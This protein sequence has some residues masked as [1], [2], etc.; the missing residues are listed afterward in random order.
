L[1]VRKKDGLGANG[2]ALLSAS[3]NFLFGKSW[4]FFALAVLLLS[5]CYVSGATGSRALPRLAGE[6]PTMPVNSRPHFDLTSELL[7]HNVLD[8]RILRVPRN[9]GGFMFQFDH[10]PRFLDV[11]APQ[12]FRPDWKPSAEMFIGEQKPYLSQYGLQARTFARLAQTVSLSR[13]GAREFLPALTAFLLAVALAVVLTL[14]ARLWGFASAAA[15]LAFCIFSTGLNLFSTSLYWVSFLLAAPMSLMALALLSEVQSFRGWSLIYLAL[16]ALFIAK[17]LAGYE[18]LTLVASAAAIPFFLA[19][20]AGRLDGSSAARHVATVALVSLVSFVGAAALHIQMASAT[21]GSDALTHLLSRGGQWALVQES[22][23]AVQLLQFG[24]VGL[25]NLVDL[26][27]YGVPTLLAFAA[28]G[29]SLVLASRSLLRRE[30]DGEAARIVLTLAAAF[31]VSVSWLIFQPQHVA[32]HPRYVAL[33]LAFPFGIVASAAAVRL[34]QLGRPF[35]DTSGRV[36]H[37]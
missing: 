18:F 1:G 13:E 37:P 20:S 21:V 31:L 10:D 28:G 34:A 15:A 32:F 36:D 3:K 16:F 33:L 23:F 14:L 30:L 9:A 17:F 22:S 19:W 29:L 2:L 12:H 24:K 4:T 25:I 5:V 35:H 27:G 6:Y 7:V 26:A 11:S 8:E